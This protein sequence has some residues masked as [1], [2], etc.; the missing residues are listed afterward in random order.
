MTPFSHKNNFNFLRLFFASLV[1]LS[2]A[3]ALLGQ[4]EPTLWGRSLGNLSVHGFFVISGYLICQSY[5]RSPTLI[6]FTIN[7]LLRIG[8]GLI[9]AIIVTKLVAD[10]CGGFK[11]NPVPYIA[12]G[13]VWTLTW[14]VACYFGLAILGL[15]GALQSNNIP[16]FFATAWLVF[17]ANIS[18]TS[19]SYLVIAPLAMMFLAGSFIAV[20]ENQ[21][22]FKK[23]PLIGILGL[24]AITNYGVFQSI[25]GWIVSHIP[26][27]WGPTVTAE[28]VSR[29]IYLAIFP[30]VV[31][32][33][34][35]LKRPVVNI[36][37]DVSYGVYIYGWPTAQT[38]VYLAIQ[39]Q[40][41]LSP[42][43]YFA[44]TMAL[45][46]PL[47]FASWKLVEKPCLSL[48]RLFIHGKRTG[49]KPQEAVR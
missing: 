5:V 7:R 15:V 23:I 25:Y 39:R 31:I 32:Y 9:I 30:L 8:P 26:F 2:H 49:L 42:A 35:K 1:V 43:T 48:K 38:L 19:D 34:G 45:T 4:E 11:A 37:N 33:I 29:V 10:L 27:L 24:A 17:L 18:N 20:M 28:Q 44:L 12:N 16:G 47:A 41:T 6:S 40:I 21:I 36:E 46:L 22:D 3:Y 14:E 13:P